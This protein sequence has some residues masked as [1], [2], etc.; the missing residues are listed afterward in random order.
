M[1]R[2][3]DEDLYRKGPCGILKSRY[4]IDLSFPH[5][6]ALWWVFGLCYA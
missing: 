5:G 6:L 4:N 1:T 2:D 3:F